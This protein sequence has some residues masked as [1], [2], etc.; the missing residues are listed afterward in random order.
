LYHHFGDKEGLYDAVAAYGFEQY[1][2]A[3]R[4]LEHTDDPVLDLKN[5]WDAHV[6]FGV[7]NPA[8]YSLM[9]GNS[10]ARVDSPAAL[11]ARNVLVELLRGVAA[12]GRL[13]HGV[14]LCTSVVEAA[15]VGAT[16]Q[17]IRDGLEPAACAHLRDT[18]VA[19]ITAGEET[20]PAEAPPFVSL[21]H[22]L[23]NTLNDPAA[24]GKLRTT[25]LALLREWL[26]VLAG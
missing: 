12:S 13:S 22:R 9:Y 15:C 16:L 24:A 4:S 14:D 3:K 20:R 17:A 19:S 6:M 5:A 25:E 21:A 18:V 2:E 10:R 8:L 7:G 11:E 26:S 1:V 23:A